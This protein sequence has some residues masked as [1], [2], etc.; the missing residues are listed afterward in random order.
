MRREKDGVAAVRQYGG[1]LLRALH[2]EQIRERQPRENLKPQKAEFPY[3]SGE[4]RLVGRGA[5]VD[6]ALVSRP[7][8]R[9]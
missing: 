9:A 5:V 4:G 7:Y 2:N 1:R 3:P 8:E 6:A